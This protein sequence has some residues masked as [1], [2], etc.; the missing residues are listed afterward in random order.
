MLLEIKEL[1]LEQQFM[2]KSRLEA[3]V[4]KAKPSLV[5]MF[6]LQERSFFDR[7]FLGSAAEEFTF[8]SSVPL[9]VF[10]K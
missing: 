2:A 5:A 4:K 8:S 9:L 10:K 1:E 3:A 7:I 6:T